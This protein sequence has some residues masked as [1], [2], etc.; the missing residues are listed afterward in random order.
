MT[1][2]SSLAA[3]LLTTKFKAP[4]VR[5][6]QVER[7]RLLRKLAPAAGVRF[8]LISAPAGAGKSTLLSQWRA[9]TE[10]PVAWLS[11]D[12]RD[13]ALHRFL[14][15]FIAALQQVDACMGMEADDLLWALQ[16]PVV[17]P[18]L[19]R[20]LNDAASAPQPFSLVLDD[21]HLITESQIHDALLF[22][23]NH[24]PRSLHLVI[25][26]R[27]DPPWPLAR[28]RARQE[29]VEIREGALRFTSMEVTALLNDVAGLALPAE[30]V[31]QLEA[32]MEGWVAGLHL[33][34]LALRE[35]G[36]E[37]RRELTQRLVDN[38]AAGHHFLID[39]LTEEVLAQQPARLREFLLQ[40]ALLERM[41]GPLCDA[42]TGGL[43]GTETLALLARR[44]TFIVPLD[45][46]RRW[47]RYHHLFAT[48][49]QRRLHETFSAEI[50]ALY[51]RA[52]EWCEAQDLIEEAMAYA[53]KAG[54]RHRAAQ[55][56]ERYGMRFIARGDTAT[57]GHWLAA[58]PEA[59][60]DERLQL[61]V[62]RAA[63]AH[64]TGDRAR[65]Y[66][67]LEQAEKL[68][69]DLSKKGVE[70]PVQILGNID[71]IRA[72]TALV[73][74]EVEFA[75]ERAERALTRLKYGDI[76]YCKAADGLGGAYWGLGDR[77][78]SER[79]FREAYRS[80]L[81]G[82]HR[83]YAVIPAT[84]VAL[85]QIKQGRLHEAVDTCDSAWKLGT[86]ARER[87]L[88]VAGFP[89][90]RLGDVQREWNQLDRAEVTLQQALDLCQRLNHLDILADAHVALARLR[91][92]RGEWESTAEHIAAAEQLVAQ[93]NVDGFVESWLQGIRLRLWLATDQLAAAV[94]WAEQ[95]D[96]RPDGEL[97][98]YFDL[99]HIHLARL[100]LAQAEAENDDSYLHAA[101]S[102]LTRLA[103][104]ADRAGWIHDLI[105]VR[106][107]QARAHAMGNEK[108]S[109]RK[110][111][112]AA[113]RL[114]E[115]GR[116]TRSFVDEG[117]VVVALLR[118]VDE[119]SSYVSVLLA[120]T[121][122][123]GP[124]QPYRHLPD[125]L[126]ERELEVLRFL[127]THL[128]ST[129]IAEALTVSANTVR[130]HIKNIYGKLGVHSR[131]E[132]VARAKAL[133]IL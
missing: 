54:D 13:N 53:L 55:L 124:P 87:P 90:I 33:A 122:S 6:D 1:N 40:T 91:L 48:L 107:L 112:A 133:E 97:S 121:V 9:S 83:R 84:Y 115:P 57:V 125:P 76:L 82:G 38:F 126:S 64:W 8:T 27:A 69:A 66:H 18:L 81:A 26:T 94:Q 85:Q 119:P 34:T 35:S 114:A 44:N 127:P 31:A 37:A 32:Q 68:A 92:T 86:D 67:Y 59:M 88:P 51:R 7:P 45:A 102:L 30:L 5:A 46:E 95:H 103:Q 20:I 52:G 25:A 50:P 21:Y 2:E 71:S 61:S 98:Y 16:P 41:C 72:H 60:I 56:V 79:A 123:D 39:Y 129:E 43:D 132:A 29:L 17:E 93:T 128:T 99:H 105:Q 108:A 75:R 3:P 109:A 63:T 62:F 89:A 130:T 58:L 111:L 101:Q 70:V 118:Q 22:L 104:A 117:P 113:V 131:G 96:L 116:Y 110:A 42:V 47:Y 77:A 80:A 106:L 120:A 23:I 78:A 24:L 36:A 100:L 28:M 15:Y 65:V 12:A 14:R 49:L 73:A 4:P 11:L 19:I 74:G 10:R